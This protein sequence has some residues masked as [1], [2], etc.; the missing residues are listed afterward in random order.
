MVQVNPCLTAPEGSQLASACA[1][2]ESVRSVQ[3]L[4]TQY[5]NAFKKWEKDN[6]AY[7][8]AKQDQQKWDNDVR[9][10]RQRFR[11]YT[12]HCGENCASGF[13]ETGYSV[14][15]VY[16]KRNCSPNAGHV[17]AVCESGTRPVNP[18][19]EYPPEQPKPPGGIQIQCCSQIFQNIKTTGNINISDVNQ[20]CNAQLNNY[21]SQQSKATPSSRTDV[22]IRTQSPSAPKPSKK[23]STGAWVGIGAGSLVIL[24]LLIYLIFT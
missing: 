6:R 3:E 14:C 20:Q 18:F 2:Q 12:A 4:V 7:Q 8:K 1:C 21:I 17:T 15:G 13:D 9:S 22:N 16:H 5:S 19:G 11:G 24:A 23:L 10:C